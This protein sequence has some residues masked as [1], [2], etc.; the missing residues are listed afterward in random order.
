MKKN[1]SD[2]VVGD[3]VYAIEITGSKINSEDAIKEYKVMEIEEV[4]SSLHSRIKLSNNIVITPTDLFPYHTTSDENINLVGNRL[5]D[6]YE[7][8]YATDKEECLRIASNSIKVRHSRLGRL[9][10]SC[11]IQMDML[12]QC[13]KDLYKVKENLPVEIVTEAVIV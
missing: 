13:S 11:K 5:C 9:I 1:F 2:L 8:V 6:Y 3:S 7:E 4:P 10:E 12:S